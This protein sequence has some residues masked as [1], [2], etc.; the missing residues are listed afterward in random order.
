[1]ELVYLVH[2]HTL[3]LISEDVEKHIKIQHNMETLTFLTPWNYF[4][5]IVRRGEKKL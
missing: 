2:T 4:F 3:A 1:M 5:Y